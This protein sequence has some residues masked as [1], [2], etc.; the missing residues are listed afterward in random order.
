MSKEINEQIALERDAARYRYLRNTQNLRDDNYEQAP[1][2]T[3]ES[4]MVV[5]VVGEEDGYGRGSSAPYGTDLDEAIDAAIAKMESENQKIAK[6]DAGHH[7]LLLLLAGMVESYDVV[8]NEL[9]L[10]KTA[11]QCIKGAFIG[12]ID[13]SRTLIEEIKSL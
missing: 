13:K 2:G 11:K 6:I 7:A 4:I 3:V 5:D 8:M 9:P 12:T 1:V 10:N